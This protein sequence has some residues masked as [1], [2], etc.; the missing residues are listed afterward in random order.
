MRRSWT[1]SPNAIFE[2]RS[3]T[4]ELRTIRRSEHPCGDGPI[5]SAEKISPVRDERSPKKLLPLTGAYF[6][7]PR[8]EQGGIAWDLVTC[9]DLEAWSAISHREFWPLILEVLA[10]NWNLDLLT[11]DRLLHDHHTGLP[12]GRVIHPKSGYFVIHGD[13][14]P[15]AVPDWLDLVKSRFQLAGVEVSPEFT[16]HEQMLADDPKALQAALGISLD[17][18]TTA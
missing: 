5:N 8:P 9:H 11:L 15:A 4:P 17:L 18:K 13:D 3:P 1:T 6:W 16:E 14:A 12:R 2:R 7:V 10:K